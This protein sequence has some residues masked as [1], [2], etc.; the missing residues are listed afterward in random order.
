MSSAEPGINVLLGTLD[1]SELPEA[2]AAR[3]FILLQFESSDHVCAGRALR[4]GL[5]KGKGGNLGPH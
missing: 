1:D 4:K 2:E 5:E 3:A